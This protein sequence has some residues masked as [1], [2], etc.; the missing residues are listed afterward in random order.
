MAQDVLNNIKSNKYTLIKKP[1]CKE[2]I[3]VRNENNKK[4]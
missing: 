4:N 3:E 2:E 1:Y